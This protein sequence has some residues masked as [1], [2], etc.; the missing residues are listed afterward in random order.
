M[1]K[2]AFFIDVDFHKGCRLSNAS[3]VHPNARP[4]GYFMFCYV[5][6]LVCI[7]E[8]WERWD[9]KCPVSPIHSGRHYLS[10]YRYV[11]NVL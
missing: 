5:C 9:A 3:I 10:I 8:N 11:A 7:G 6:I 4:K 1:N 2:A